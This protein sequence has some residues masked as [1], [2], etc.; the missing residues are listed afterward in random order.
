MR[1]TVCAPEGAG[2]ERP[3][4]FCFHNLPHKGAKGQ[5]QR[6]H[7]E[8]VRTSGPI[9]ALAY[10]GGELSPSAAF[11]SPR[12]P[13]HPRVPRLPKALAGV[14]A[15][16]LAGTSAQHIQGEPSQISLCYFK[17]TKDSGPLPRSHKYLHSHARPG[18]LT[19]PPGEAGSQQRVGGLQREQLGGS[20][21]LREPVH[22]ER[23]TQ[24]L[25]V[26]EVSS[27]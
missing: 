27:E 20:T 17:P 14:D 18:R 25:P 10:H 26:T 21:V 22:G 24:G 13:G 12:C 1:G 23:L 5:S 3:C 6:Q 11:S 15:P 8:L 7:R 2:R 19:N 16:C 4:A 9:A